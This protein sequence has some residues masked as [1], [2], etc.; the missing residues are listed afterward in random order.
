[1][2]GDI[3]IGISGWTYEGWR[4][5]FYPEGLPHR[6]ELH[7]AARQVNSIE[8]NGTFYSLQRPSNYQLWYN[9]TPHDFIFSLKGPRFITHIKRLKDCE[10]P[11]ANFLA[12][13]IFHLKEKLGP[14]LW[15]LP[16]RFLY[17]REVM[18]KFLA[19]LPC[20]TASAARFS[21]QSDEHLKYAPYREIDKNRPLRHAVEVRHPSFADPDYI[22]LLNDYGIALV[23]ARGRKEWPYMEDVTAGFIY[24]RLHGDKQVYVSGYGPKALDR[25]AK[26]L[27][28]WRSGGEPGD[29]ERIHNPVPSGKQ[30]DIYV[31][32]DN[33]VKVRAP[34]DAMSLL[35]RMTD[36][37]P[38][39]TPR[40]PNLKAL[41]NIYGPRVTRRKK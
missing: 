41:K 30:R 38:A 19:M 18:E 24:V 7:F 28:I 11:L 26:R 25:W 40:K 2:A 3:R 27:E 29:A 1:M 8:I 9:E 33:D 13:G 4:G 20:D 23:F 32:F 22:K 14:I 12:S 31:Y 16:P 6:K 39:H 5:P 37:K 34:Y 10:V 21:Q 17:R 35:S 15:Q 36:F